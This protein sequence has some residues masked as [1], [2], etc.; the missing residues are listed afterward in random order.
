MQCICVGCVS[1]W[2]CARA[3]DTILQLTR[4]LSAAQEKVLLTEQV[5]GQR[6]DELEAAHAQLQV[7]L[8]FVRY[9]HMAPRSVFDQKHSP[10]ILNPALVLTPIQ[11]HAF[12]ATK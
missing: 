2:W 9:K 7:T 4:D 11:L 1:D 8:S 5:L 12:P 10:P 3:Q 6:M